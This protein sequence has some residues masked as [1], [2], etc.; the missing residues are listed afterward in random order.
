MKKIFQEKTITKN[1]KTA[2]ASFEAKTLFYL[3]WSILVR[4]SVNGRVVYENSKL[5]L[6]EREWRYEQ[7]Y[8]E[9]HISIT[10]SNLVFGDETIEF[11]IT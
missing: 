7:K 1:N 5:I 8:D 6:S 2:I 3:G 11:K 10:Y 4:L 9:F